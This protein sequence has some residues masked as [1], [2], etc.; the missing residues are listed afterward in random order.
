MENPLKNFF[1]FSRFFRSGSESAVGIDIGSSFIKIVQLKK[2]GGRAILE[3][4]GELALGP[5]AG[6]VTGQITNLSGDK[7]AEALSDILKEA[8][9]STKSSAISIPFSASLISLI[10]LPKASENQLDTVIPLEARKYIPVPIS[11]V[12]LDWWIVPRR[13]EYETEAEKKPDPKTQKIDVM[14]AA[15]H[16]DTIDKY[17]DVIRRVG[18]TD[19]FF[20]IETFSTIRSTFGHDMK[21]IMV[22]DMGAGTTKLSIVEH[23]IVKSSHVISRGSQDITVALSRSL[24]ISLESAEEMKRAYGLIGK[25]GS[26]EIAKTVSLS[27]DYIFSEVNRVL[28]NYEKK[29]NKTIDKVILTGGGVLLRG[30][31]EAAVSILRAEALYGDSFSKIEFPAFLG[32]TLREAGPEFSVAIGLALRKLQENNP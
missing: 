7:L 25:E 32:D 15:I 31:K 29:Y 27:T 14:I 22:L 24:S 3:T 2:K 16:N 5:Y 20:E 19:V 23:G 10:E 18:V 13:D 30:F 11:E 8:H 21:L 12:S 26:P 17:K 28:L 1:N 4:Y 6:L 9:V